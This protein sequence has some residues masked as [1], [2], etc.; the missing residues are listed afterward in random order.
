MQRQ[1]ARSITMM[2][3]GLFMV[4]ETEG[5]ENR[6]TFLCPPVRHLIASNYRGTIMAIEGLSQQLWSS[7][8]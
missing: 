1:Q 3:G 6:S 7:Q 2:R 5:M 4:E 8:L